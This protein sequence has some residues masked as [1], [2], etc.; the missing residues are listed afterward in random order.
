MKLET[1]T[2]NA[3]SNESQRQYSIGNWGSGSICKPNN[4]SS[5][6]ANRKFIRAEKLALINECILHN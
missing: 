3:F 1:R 6:K 5:V 4:V 2:N